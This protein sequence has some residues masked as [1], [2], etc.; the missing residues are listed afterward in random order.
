MFKP[1]FQLSQ[2]SNYS[3]NLSNTLLGTSYEGQLI[4]GNYMLEFPVP[5]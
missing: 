2:S 4:H 3:P 5:I 1:T